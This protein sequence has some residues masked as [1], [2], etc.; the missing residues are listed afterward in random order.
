VA[1]EYAR[2]CQLRLV[3]LRYFNVYGPRESYKGRMASMILQLG[4]QLLAGR[5]P[6]LFKFGEQKRDF[7]FVQD[8]VQANLRALTARQSGVYNVGTGRAREFREVLAILQDVLGLHPE[9]E[10]ID[11]PWEF[12]QDHT[13]ADIA[14][15]TEALGYRPQFT[16]EA[17]IES[18]AAELRRLAKGISP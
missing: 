3:G 17:G 15:T 5:R 1:R 16:L 2:T 18:Y 7:V 11:N 9:V 10:Y 6:R 14:P 4:L 13:E 12:Y 8:V